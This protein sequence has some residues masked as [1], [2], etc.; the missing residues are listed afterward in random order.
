M[1]LFHA[2]VRRKEDESTR[3]PRESWA[4][5]NGVKLGKKVRRDS[6]SLY[7]TESRSLI[8]GAESV[9]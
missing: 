4:S 8:N 2:F 9:K 3:G 7:N 1:L 5:T 6:Q